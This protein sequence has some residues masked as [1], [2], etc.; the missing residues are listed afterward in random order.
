MIQL[1]DTK[2]GRVLKINGYLGSGS[3]AFFALLAER[4]GLPVA[5]LVKQA[6]YPG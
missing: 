5:D 6:R 3:D 1:E 2:D 4:T